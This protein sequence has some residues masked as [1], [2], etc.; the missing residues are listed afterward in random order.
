M[1][2]NELIAG[3]RSD[4][5]VKVY[6][7]DFDQLTDTANSIAAVLRTVQGGADIKVEQTTGLPLLD[8][9]LEQDGDRAPRAQHLRRTGCGLDRRSAGREVGEWCFRAIGGST[10]WFA[11]PIDLRQDIAGLENLPIPC[12]ATA[13]ARTAASCAVRPSSRSRPW[14]NSRVGEGPNQ[15]SRENGKRRVVVQA[16][17]R[18][19]DIGSFVAEAQAEDRARGQD[20]AGSWLEWGGQFEN[21]IAARN[22]LLIVV[23]ACFFVIFLMLFTAFGSAREALLVF[24]WRTAGNLRRD[25][26]ALFLGHA[27]FDLRRGWLHRAVGRRRAQR[28]GDG[29]LHQPAA[30]EGRGWANEAIIEGALTRLRPVLMT[31][32]VAALGFVPM[33]IAAGTGAE[34][35]KPSATVVIGGLITCDAPYPRGSA[36]PLQTLCPQRN[37]TAGSCCQPREGDPSMMLMRFAFACALAVAVAYAGPAPPRRK[38]I[39]TP[40]SRISKSRVPPTSKLLGR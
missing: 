4:V 29:H 15:I 31:A 33:A 11:C 13:A 28:P 40:R 34:V 24:I 20:P 39:A 26:G 35:Q 23:P 2:F 3:V 27:V 16:N 8:V 18:G 38:T 32:L 17:V 36:G 37:H 7:D 1:R 25:S 10:L 6:G 19:R 9:K 21:L 14:P 12:L 30:T 22:R 5:A